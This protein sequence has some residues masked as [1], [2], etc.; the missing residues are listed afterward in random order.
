MREWMKQIPAS[1]FDVY[2]KTGFGGAVKI[3]DRPAL[4]VV[5]A[6][7]GF[8]GS[9]GAS[10]EEAIREYSTA[11]GPIAWQC[12]PRIARLIELFRA[13]RHPVVFTRSAAYDVLFTGNATKSNRR[14]LPPP[15]FND[16]PAAI[17]PRDGEWALAKTKASAFFQTPLLQY[18]VQRSIDALVVCGVSTSGCV[19]ATVV[20]AFSNGFATFVVEDCCFDRSYFAHCANLFDMNAKYAAVVSLEEV[21]GVLDKKHGA[22]LAIA[23]E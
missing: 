3:G 14:S 18:L 7:F 13:R 20:D 8:T 21:E 17:A 10:F 16:F 12:M 15:G 23:A 9:E 22:D 19:R 1:E 2:S 5:D 4:V 11:T 6:T